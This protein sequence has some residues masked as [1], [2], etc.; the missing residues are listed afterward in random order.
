MGELAGGLL[1][2]L[3]KGRSMSPLLVTM[4]ECCWSAARAGALLA[5]LHV[6]GGL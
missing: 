6:P 1:V 5:A 3:Q 2:A 4:T